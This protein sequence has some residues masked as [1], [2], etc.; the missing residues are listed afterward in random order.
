MSHGIQST[1]IVGFRGIGAL[2]LIGAHLRMFALGAD[3]SRLASDQWLLHAAVNWHTWLDTAMAVSAYYWTRRLL[4]VEET[5]TRRVVRRALR[6]W[7]TFLLVLPFHVALSYSFRGWAAV[8]AVPAD[9]LLLT[10]GWRFYESN[11]AYTWS[12]ALDIQAHIVLALLAVLLARRRPTHMYILCLLGA[13]ASVVYRFHCLFGPDAYLPSPTLH[14]QDIAV[15]TPF[16]G[17]YRRWMAEFYT[18]IAPR[19][20]PAFIG[21]LGG[22]A[23][24]LPH[25][26]VLRRVLETNALLVVAVGSAM[27]TTPFIFP[28]LPYHTGVVGTATRVNLAL[29]RA[30][31]A[32][33]GTVIVLRALRL[34]E[35]AAKAKAEA[36]ADGTADGKPL[37]SPLDSEPSYVRT[38]VAVWSTPLLQPFGYYTYG[39]YHVNA[40]VCLSLAFYFG[41]ALAHPGTYLGVFA[42]AVVLVFSLGV[43]L[44]RLVEALMIRWGP[45]ST[46]SVVQTATKG[47]GKGEERMKRD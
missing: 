35:A 36:E 43:L 23:S 32:L 13:V 25:A 11:V 44:H 22:A 40:L 31:W 20:G 14:L 5:W 29:C 33:A 24:L 17:P 1:I 3:P 12:L 34:D 18:P 45:A 19:I 6:F 27:L 2:Q 30:I 9:L 41:P 38:F 37:P 16:N 21:G 39:M 28:S 7:P 26:H 47:T 4:A 8:E 42:L 15:V 46:R 10:T